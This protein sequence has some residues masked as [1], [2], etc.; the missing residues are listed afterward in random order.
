[1]RTSLF[2]GLLA[3]LGA[4][5]VPLPSSSDGTAWAEI[6]Q[7]RVPLD[8]MA[9]PMNLTTYN[10]TIVGAAFMGAKGFG[11]GF[12]SAS[13]ATLLADCKT[14]SDAGNRWFSGC[15]PNGMRDSLMNHFSPQRWVVRSTQE[16]LSTTRGDMINAMA[17]GV[18]S[19]TLQTP[20]VLPLYG[21][22][23]HWV[24]LWKVDV[25][26]NLTT[27]V[28][29]V[30][31]QAIINDAVAMQD[32][33]S[34][35]NDAVT[36]DWTTGATFAEDYV[37]VL[38]AVGP[39][40]RVC[41][42]TDP[43]DPRDP[44]YCKPCGDP[45]L[46]SLVY[47]IEPPLGTPPIVDA[48]ESPPVTFL[49]APGWLPAGVRLSAELAAQQVFHAIE[50]ANLPDDGTVQERLRRGAAGQAYEVIGRLLE[51]EP[52]DYMVVPIVDKNPSSQQAL[53]FVR[54]DAR[55]GAFM[56]ISLPRAGFMY[57]PLTGQQA[58]GPAMALLKPG[59]S[60]GS[61]GL[62]WDA[63]ELHAA[64]RKPWQAFYEF[65][66]Q[67]DNATTSEVIRVAHNG[68][69]VLGRMWATDPLN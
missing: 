67:K 28:V 46:K 63:S 21:R 9:D 12:A 17:G 5:M 64:A 57:R 44:R 55:D 25:D 51:G 58:A 56:E 14:F 65:P 27:G 47:L 13:L 68:G 36:Q 54:L 6:K 10:P 69:A 48:K 18:A 29:S 53:A 42:L 59:E 49:R 37:R 43:T 20:S 15:N 40:C 24:T 60:L 33:A 22:G 1:M 8:P 41:K 16:T 52:R 23:D 35:P 66:V 19:A 11:I 62:H 45:F 3:G 50:L 30:L 38:A 26:R 7:S 32:G 39:D 61:P 4:V 31:S 34:P 2:L